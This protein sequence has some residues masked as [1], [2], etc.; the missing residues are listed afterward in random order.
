MS[1][2]SA[3]EPSIGVVVNGY[4]LIFLLEALHDAII[5]R[6]WLCTS[7]EHQEYRQTTPLTN[8]QNTLQALLSIYGRSWQEYL[9][10][11]DGEPETPNKLIWES[12][13]ALSD[14]T[15]EVVTL[16][17]A[18]SEWKDVPFHGYDLEHCEVCDKVATVLA[19][20]G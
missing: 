12:L 10:I 17:V 1:N 3:G 7:E 14:E 2:V 8:N 6:I 13:H 20:L 9:S 15:W 4:E 11:T 18:A 5:Q 16:I 19:A